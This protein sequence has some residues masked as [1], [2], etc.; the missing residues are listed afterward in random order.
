MVGAK[1]YEAGDPGSI[2]P[3]VKYFLHFFFI[4][5]KNTLKFCRV[6]LH[7]D[8][9]LVSIATSGLLPATDSRCQ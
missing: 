2:P 3:V 6:R 8:H 4:L 1:E 9:Q 7:T 5:L